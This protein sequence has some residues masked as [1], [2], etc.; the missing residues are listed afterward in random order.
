MYI[1]VSGSM[2][3]SSEIWS[4]AIALV[5]AEEA[6]KQK[7]TL[8]INLFD[9]YIQ[10]TVVVKPDNNSQE[11]LDFVGS[12]SLHGGTSFNAV[13]DHALKN[14]EL[15]KQSDVLMITDG[16]SSVSDAFLRRL[17]L[18]KEREGIQWT[19]LCLSRRL[20]PVVATFSD[21]AYL[22]NIEDDH[23]TADV[24]QKALR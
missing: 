6:L 24:I 3:G 2:T 10:D 15:V 4:K 9:T 22:V 19:T 16:E 12:W 17:S 8:Q 23:N 5:I 18:Y 7:R 13:I 1:D 14:P 21:D 20:P 11:L